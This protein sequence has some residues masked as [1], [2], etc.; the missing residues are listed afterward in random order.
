MLEIETKRHRLKLRQKNE[1][2]NLKQQTIEIKM[3]LVNNS[4]TSLNLENKQPDVYLMSN[5]LYERSG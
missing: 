3:L 2:T 4:T 5:L 1:R